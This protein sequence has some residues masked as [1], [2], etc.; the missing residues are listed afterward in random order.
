MAEKA[1]PY[2]FR[3]LTKENF[4][5]PDPVSSLWRL[6]NRTT[7]ESRPMSAPDWA[8]GILHSQLSET[9]PEEIRRA[10]EVARSPLLYGFFFY[11]LFALGMSQ[12]LQV[13]EMAVRVAADAAQAPNSCKTFEKRIDWLES[14]GNLTAVAAQRWHAGRY[15]RN[16]FVHELRPSALPPTIAMGELETLVADINELFSATTFE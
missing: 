2:G 15:L 9:V 1:G 11:P 12:L 7:G 8:E 14:Q 16:T 13:G 6:H 5:S 4:L 10:F 3:Q